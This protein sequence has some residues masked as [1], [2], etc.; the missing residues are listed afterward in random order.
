MA[1]FH[2]RPRGAR[3]GS[4]PLGAGYEGCWR[5]R[6][7]QCCARNARQRPSVYGRASVHRLV[8]HPHLGNKDGAAVA[9]ARRVIR[10]F[11]FAMAIYVALAVL[12]VAGVRPRDL[13]E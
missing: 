1:E 3:D 13:I 5:L 10:D 6:F 2:S 7:D 4:S 8:S 9:W 12:R 11:V